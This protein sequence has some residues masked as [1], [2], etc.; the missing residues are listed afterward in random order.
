M[1]ENVTSSEDL[2]HITATEDLI[3]LGVP[4]KKLSEIEGFNNLPEFKEMFIPLKELSEKKGFEELSKS[5]NTING[6]NKNA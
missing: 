1:K 4:L 5:N 2:I 3:R 6:G